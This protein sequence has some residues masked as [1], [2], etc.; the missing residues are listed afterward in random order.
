[1]MLN[2]TVQNQ[3]DAGRVGCVQCEGD[4]RRERPCIWFSLVNAGCI[5]LQ[6]YS[7]GSLQTATLRGYRPKFSC[8]LSR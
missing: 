1:M 2:T 8:I 7:T 3:K 5:P 4:A 6:L